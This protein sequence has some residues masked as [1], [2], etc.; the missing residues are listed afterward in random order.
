MG[1]RHRRTVWVPHDFHTSVK[2]F[3]QCLDDDRAQSMSCL[4]QIR[5]A[6]RYSNPIVGNRKRPARASRLIGNDKLASGPV[7][8]KGMLECIDHKLRDN[9]ADADR[10]GG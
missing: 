6:V 1:N 3:S 10:L 8:D 7:A 2:L 9:E 5:S 4:I